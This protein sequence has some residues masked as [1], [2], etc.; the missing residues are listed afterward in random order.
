MLTTLTLLSDA[1]LVGG[2]AFL[3]RHFTIHTDTG[4]VDS[5]R[6]HIGVVKV[7]LCAVALIYLLQVDTLIPPLRS[8]P[9]FLIVSLAL[10]LAC[11]ALA[12]I[13][14][15]Y[16]Y[17]ARI[18]ERHLLTGYLALISL[19]AGGVNKISMS[20]LAP[21]WLAPA[22]LAVLGLMILVSACLLVMV[23]VLFRRMRAAAKSAV[24]R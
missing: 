23:F 11:L 4:A 1:A 3:L 13:S 15:W 7:L 19:M 8:A 9:P 24:D 14:L 20:G 21:A 12:L 18:R 22:W 6:V 17:R 5:T 16:M 10:T 2:L